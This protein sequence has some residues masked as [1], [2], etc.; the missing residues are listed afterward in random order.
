MRCKSSLIEVLGLLIG[1]ASL[2][3][4]LAQGGQKVDMSPSSHEYSL[5]NGIRPYYAEPPAPPRRGYYDYYQPELCDPYY[6][7]CSQC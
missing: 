3:L 1:I 4:A 2:A 5:R 7:D 6:C